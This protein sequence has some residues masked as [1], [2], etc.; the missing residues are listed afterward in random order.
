MSN[1]SVED[2][3]HHIFIQ[4]DGVTTNYNEGNNYLLAYNINKFTHETF[5]AVLAEM[6]RRGFTIKLMDVWPKS[7]KQVTVRMQF[8]RETD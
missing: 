2:Y 3:F 7:K 5:K 6:E 1:L 8:E 4:G